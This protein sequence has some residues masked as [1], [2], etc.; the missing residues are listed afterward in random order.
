MAPENVRFYV[1]TAQA[2]PEERERLM[3]LGFDGILMKPFHSHEL[4]DL[5]KESSGIRPELAETQFDFTA[6]SEMTFGDEA[7]MREILEQFVNDMR[8][9]L[10]DLQPFVD[11]NDKNNISEIMHKL[12]GRTGQMGIKD[13]A[14]KF[15]KYE[16]SFRN[17]DPGVS[18]A[19]LPQF[20]SE[21][22]SIID[23]VEEKALT[24]SI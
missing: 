2:L 16:I 23:Q 18:V 5:L 14:E 11:Q 7:L 8:K 10:N 21:S 6:I 13:L 1:L 24:Y 15:R 19:E 12:A 20:V 17:N 4:L 9:D 22:L 3:K